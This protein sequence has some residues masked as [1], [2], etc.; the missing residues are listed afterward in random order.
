ML[1]IKRKDLYLIHFYDYHDLFRSRDSNFIACIKQPL[2]KSQLFRLLDF[3][4]FFQ[5]QQVHEQIYQ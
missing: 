2:K 5:Q 3:H 1:A 4:Q